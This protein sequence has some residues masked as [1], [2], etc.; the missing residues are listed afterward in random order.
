MRWKRRIGF[1][2]TVF[3]SE[4]MYVVELIIFLIHSTM[5]NSIIYLASF[6][7]NNKSDKYFPNNI[8]KGTVF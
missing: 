2:N 3:K 1:K 7:K 5:N 4:N 6:Y 8:L